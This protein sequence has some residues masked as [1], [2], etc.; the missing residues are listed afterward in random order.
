MNRRLWVYG[1]AVLFLTW[2]PTQPT[3]AQAPLSS[4]EPILEEMGKKIE[5]RNVPTPERLEVIRLLG[6]WASPGARPA[7]LTVLKDPDPQIRAA[8][9]KALGWPGDDEA[10]AP[11]KERAGAPGEVASVRAAAIRSLGQ[12]GDR[13]VRP[14]VVAAIADPNAS[15]REAALWGVALGSLVDPA[16]RTSYLIQFAGS[17][18]FDAQARA[19]AI[20]ALAT[21]NEERVVES[22]SRILETEP[23]VRMVM[24]PGGLNQQQIMALRYAQIKDV[25][26]WAART[27]GVLQAKSA[28]PLLLQTAED[29]KDF[30]LRLMSLQALVTWKAPE[31]YPVMVRRLEDPLPE[32]RAM[33]LT[34]IAVLH[35]PRGVEPV[36]AVLSDSNAEVRATAVATLTVLGDPKV[37]PQLE[38]LQEKESDPN[39]RYVLENALAKI[40]P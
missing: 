8:A 28:L 39:V 32:M 33:A 24:P 19:D 5:D 27:L 3:G 20:R 4:A 26:A 25:A 13:S 22:L 34:G 9:A 38:A 36:L 30:F 12:I 29:P 1:A 6:E 10:V 37:R 14:L 40:G 16:D 11:L 15:V 21:V 17:R 23:R 7:L 31:A 35:D 2:A 18:G